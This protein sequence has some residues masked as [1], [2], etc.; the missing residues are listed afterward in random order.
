MSGERQIMADVMSH[1]PGVGEKYSE[2]YNTAL[3]DEEYGF[4]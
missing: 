1:W 2:A 3:F 4:T